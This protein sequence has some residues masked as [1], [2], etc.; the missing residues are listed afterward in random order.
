MNRHDVRDWIRQFLVDRN[1]GI[2]I[3][4]W[5]LF[6]DFKPEQLGKVARNE[7]VDRGLIVRLKWAINSWT[8]GRVIPKMVCVPGK[9]RTVVAIEANHVEPKLVPIHKITLGSDGPKL[10]FGVKNV[11]DYKR[12]TFGAR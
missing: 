8:T 10:E 4:Q 11:R 6:F 1:R 7:A 2:S 12:R 9:K 3:A 5:C